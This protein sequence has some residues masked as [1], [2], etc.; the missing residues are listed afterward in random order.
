MV[1]TFVA[2]G[3]PEK[4]REQIEPLWKF[5]DSL[6]VVPPVYSLPFE[7]VAGYYESIAQTFY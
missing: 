1:R 3:K 4:V 6:C 5:A 2:V 7:K